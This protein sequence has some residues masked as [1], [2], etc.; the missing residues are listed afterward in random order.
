MRT[1]L[2]W[3]IKMVVSL[4]FLIVLAVAVVIFLKIPLDLTPFREPVEI[5]LSQAINRTVKIED[6]VT[7]ST[8]LSPYFTVKGVLIENPEGFQTANFL[9]M[10]LIRIQ[11]DLL[12]L[13]KRKIHISEFQVQGLHVT[14]E[15]TADGNVNWISG[16]SSETQKKQ[17]SGPELTHLPNSSERRSGLASDTL[18]LRN[19]DLQDL[20]VS[21]HHP[22]LEKPA[23]FQLEHC[24]GKMLPG[25]PL[26]LDIDG[27]SLGFDYSMNITVGSLEELLLHN[28]SWMEMQVEI[29]E[30]TLNFTSNVDLA[31]AT[32]SLFLQT[33]VQ[34]DNLASLND[35]LQIDL[36][37][38]ARYR[39]DTGVQ[40]RPDDYE[41]HRLHIQTGESSL[42]GTARILVSPDT[43]S[44][45]V[46][47]HSPLVQIDDFVFDNWSWLGE[48]VDTVKVDEEETV[49]FSKIKE[50]RKTKEPPIST[51]N[52]SLIRDFLTQYEC[53]LLIEADKVVSGDDDLGGGLL[54]A[55]VHDG[56]LKVDP[57]MF[58]LPGGKIEMM[59]SIK[60]GI[61]KS[62]ADLKVL[63]KN[64]N[65]GILAH[66]VKPDSKMGGLINLDIDL[67]SN[68]ATM[69]ELLENGNGYFDFSGELENFEAGII[70]LWAVNLV[71]AI[72]SNAEKK[73]SRLN[74]AVGRWSA[75]DGLLQ[76][77]A[78]F[79]DTDKIRICAD[80]AVNFKNERID[81]N[82]KPR[83]KRPEFFSLATPLEVHGSFSDIKFG[84]GGGQ[85]VG[86]A[87]KFVASPISTPIQR[88][89]KS[90]IPADGSDA[91]TMQLGAEGREEIVVPLCQK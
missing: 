44:I 14:L 73:K 10:D 13:L 39:L 77:D 29:A 83:A 50:N 4:L 76:S 80:G 81:V 67:H 71:A 23:R 33:T 82:V 86:T 31:T 16:S 34:G 68:A 15:E 7:V 18:V 6:S 69:N 30:T 49:D 89:F 54:R 87:I 8:S 64:F 9:S 78:F 66:R 72:V 79:I 51:Y 35:L 56:R 74:C 62:D 3:L 25:N 36:P 47:L 19:L 2:R 70:D 12:P 38:F 53:S 41:L 48:P 28:T 90:K 88:I 55:L 1:L 5:A 58:R 22:D 91:C 42:E 65:I 40:L 20:D 26:H 45:D 84:L 37:P 17:S 75:T 60:P 27:T 46:Q 43:T 52:E 21:F 24:L 59:A 63:M 32:K 57:L 85:I 11:L 61:E